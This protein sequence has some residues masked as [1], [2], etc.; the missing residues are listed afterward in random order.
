[1]GQW[2]GSIMGSASIVLSINVVAAYSENIEMRSSGRR[3]TVHLRPPLLA[4]FVL[5]LL[6]MV[7]LLRLSIGR[8]LLF[9]FLVKFSEI[10]VSQC[11]VG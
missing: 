4:H 5:T 10:L 8:L 3:V 2:I 9:M 7:L 11:I 1:M 6:G